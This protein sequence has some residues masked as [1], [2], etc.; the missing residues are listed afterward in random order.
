MGSPNKLTTSAEVVLAAMEA[1]FSRETIVRISEKTH[2]QLFRAI[3]LKP[4]GE[5]TCETKKLR[6]KITD[7]SPY[8]AVN[9]SDIAQK[10]AEVVGVDTP[11]VAVRFPYNNAADL[12]KAADIIAHEVRKAGL[13]PEAFSARMWMSPDEGRKWR[14]IKAAMA[15]MNGPLHPAV[16]DA[17]IALEDAADLRFREEMLQPANVALKNASS[18][19]FILT[20]AIDFLTMTEGERDRLKKK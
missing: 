1:G 19:L 6:Q 2:D 11:V 18:A 10:V 13:D 7:E 4:D 5:V 14:N 17:F 20:D 8:R 16:L 12:V 3:G 9:P 15:K